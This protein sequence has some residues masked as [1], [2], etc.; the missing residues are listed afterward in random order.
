MTAIAYILLLF[1][2]LISFA[3]H[4]MAQ[5]RVAHILRHRYPDQWDIV[6]APETRGRRVRTWA[7]LQRVLRSGIPEMFDDHQLTRWH[8]CWR[9]TPWIAWPCLMGALALRAWAT[10]H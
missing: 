5:F 2:G 10:T 1:G 9:Y 3:A 6:A 4:L 7:R 8:R